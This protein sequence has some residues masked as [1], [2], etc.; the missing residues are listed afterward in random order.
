M[1][2]QVQ[3]FCSEPFLRTQPPSEERTSEHPGY[4]PF[5]NPVRPGFF[6]LDGFCQP[7][8]APAPMVDA[9]VQDFGEQVGSLL[10]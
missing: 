6:C 1:V 5:L 4:D 7:A 3:S 8:G 9:L 10:T 2:L